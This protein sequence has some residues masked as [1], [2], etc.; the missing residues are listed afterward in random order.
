MVAW[1][2][3]SFGSE[4]QRQAFLPR[5]L[6]MEQL[7]SYCLT[8]PGSGSDA[9]SLKTRAERDGD[10][11]V[12][13]GAKAFISGGGASDVRSEEHT[14]ELQSLMRISYAVFCLKKK[15]AIII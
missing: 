4:A 5:L 12:L 14:S 6:N 13:N 2:I 7:A 10:H 15:K 3:D 1:M 9:A 8:E 11:Y